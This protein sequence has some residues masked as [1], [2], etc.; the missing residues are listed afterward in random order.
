M[1]RKI[2]LSKYSL[3]DLIKANEMVTANFK[4]KESLARYHISKGHKTQPVCMPMT[5]DE[6]LIAAAYVAMNWEANADNIV[7]IVD[8][9]AVIV[10]KAKYS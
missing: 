10:V 2:D 7:A 5:L 9:K 6:R 8:D 3:A 4:R 1:S